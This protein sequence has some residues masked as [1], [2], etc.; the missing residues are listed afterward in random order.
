MGLQEAFAEQGYCFIPQQRFSREA[1]IELLRVMVPTNFFYP[2]LEC[3]NDA[4][5]RVGEPLEDRIPEILV[6]P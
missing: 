6:I 3:G 1:I 5:C 4:K 2:G